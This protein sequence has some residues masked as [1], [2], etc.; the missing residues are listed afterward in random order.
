MKAEW[1]QI[2]NELIPEDERI[3]VRHNWGQELST[4]TGKEAGRWVDGEMPAK[5]SEITNVA[6]YFGVQTITY[7]NSDC[8]EFALV[9]ANMNRAR[10]GI[11][12]SSEF[13]NKM[14]SRLHQ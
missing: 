5:F 8:G 6:G 10:E 13:F 9:W 11:V 2:L 14:L 4:T 12:I 7:Q 3:C 1:I